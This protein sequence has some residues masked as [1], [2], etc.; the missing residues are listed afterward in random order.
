MRMYCHMWII[1]DNTGRVT[2]NPDAIEPEQTA[3]LGGVTES[4][5]IEMRAAVAWMAAE[6]LPNQVWTSSP[7]GDGKTTTVVADAD[8]A[9][10][11]FMGPGLEDGAFCFH[12]IDQCDTVRLGELRAVMCVGAA[13]GGSVLAWRL[14]SLALA[15]L[16]PSVDDTLASNLHRI[17]SD[18]RIVSEMERICSEEADRSCCDNATTH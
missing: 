12:T 17:I 7:D 18:P 3:T 6:A 11:H 9:A 10:V 15:M 14:A 13:D 4:L 16:V 2:I 8:G 1:D 5:S